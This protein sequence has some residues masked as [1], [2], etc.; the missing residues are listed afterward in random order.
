MSDAMIDC[1]GEREDYERDFAVYGDEEPEE[2]GDCEEVE[3]DE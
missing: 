2:A 1:Y 3:D